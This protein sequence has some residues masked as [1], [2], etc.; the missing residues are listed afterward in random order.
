[1]TSDNKKPA[2][3]KR[4]WRCLA[5]RLGHSLVPGVTSLILFLVVGAAGYLLAQ[6]KQAPPDPHVILRKGEK[7]LW[8][9]HFSLDML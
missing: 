5:R 2:I 6:D 3:R 9:V 1:M 4:S 7:I 8:G